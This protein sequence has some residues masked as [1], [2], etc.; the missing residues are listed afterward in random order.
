MGGRIGKVKALLGSVLSVKPIA[1]IKDDILVLPRQVRTHKKSI[2]KPIEFAKSVDNIQELGIIHGT[3][4]H[5][6]SEVADAIAEFFPCEAIYIMQ[7]GS[8]VGV[9][10]GP[11]VLGVGIRT[12]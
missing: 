3:T 11:G 8:A 7:L 12:K 5:V 10:A 9:H 1:V 4:P 2:K 6:A